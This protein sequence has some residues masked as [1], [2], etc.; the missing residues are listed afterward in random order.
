[1]AEENVIQ[2][3]PFST[4]LKGALTQTM[5]AQMDMVSSGKDIIDHLA[6]QEKDGK[7]VAKMA[8]VAVNTEHGTK[9]L[10]MPLLSVSP[11]TPM[12]IDG[13]ELNFTLDLDMNEVTKRDE[14]AEGESQRTVER[15]TLPVSVAP[16][17]LLIEQKRALRNVL[18]KQQAASRVAVAS[19]S[20]FSGGKF[21]QTQRLKAEAKRLAELQKMLELQLQEEKTKEGH[22]NINSSVKLGQAE[23]P[24]GIARLL[25]IAQSQGVR[26]FDKDTRQWVFVTPEGDCYH[27][28]NCRYIKGHT[29]NKVVCDDEL[30]GKKRAC[31]VCK[32]DQK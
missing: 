20:R 24:Y 11:S 27:K 18:R 3:F 2:Q 21:R 5:Q 7:Q 19:I 26:V 9:S 4:L 23:M 6:F 1:M 13:A 30:R 32:P 16:R 28:E 22:V 31:K 12:Q 15:I 8:K 10:K 29:I 25:Q 17:R 14:K